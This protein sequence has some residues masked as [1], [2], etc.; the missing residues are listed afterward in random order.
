VIPVTGYHSFGSAG[1]GKGDIKFATLE[2]VERGIDLT[3]GC[4]C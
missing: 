4:L 1:K 3:A 2:G